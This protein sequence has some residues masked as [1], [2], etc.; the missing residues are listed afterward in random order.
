MIL[1]NED[2]LSSRVAD[3]ISGV[4]STTLFPQPL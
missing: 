1:V 3:R 2:G 4:L